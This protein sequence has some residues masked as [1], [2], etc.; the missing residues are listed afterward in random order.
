MIE[1]EEEEEQNCEKK[2]KQERAQPKGKQRKKMS[3]GGGTK[4]KE[5]KEKDL[6]ETTGPRVQRNTEK[7]KRFPSVFSPLRRTLREPPV[8]TKQG[9]K[10]PKHGISQPHAALAGAHWQPGDWHS[11]KMTL[12]P[13][14]CTCAF[15]FWH[16][17]AGPGQNLY[18]S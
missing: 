17:H 2:R 5:N 11:S 4:K 6:K 1:E 7:H 3:R 10:F 18:N 8:K 13:T 12:A 15:N 9:S 16:R 14:P